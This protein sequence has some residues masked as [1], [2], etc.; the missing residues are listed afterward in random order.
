MAE[1]LLLRCCTNMLTGRVVV[2]L[3][4]HVTK[5]LNQRALPLLAIRDHRTDPR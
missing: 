5:A 1:P 3:G 2:T 4:I